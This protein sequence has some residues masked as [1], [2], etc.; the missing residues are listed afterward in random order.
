MSKSIEERQRE[1]CRRYEADFCPPEPGSKLGVARDIVTDLQPLNGLRHRP[2]GDA[3]G[4]YIWRGG[5][6][7]PADDYFQPMH[8]EHLEGE[9][10]KALEFLAL[11]PGWRFLT[12]EGQVDVWYDP[13][14]LSTE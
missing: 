13:A 14:L 9:C 11:P 6:P 12:A 10:C 3:C 1:T 4:W 7:S 5:E 8:V 2:M